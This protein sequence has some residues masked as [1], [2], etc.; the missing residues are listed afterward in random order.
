[1]NTTTRRKVIAG[2]AA[3]P[4]LPAAALAVP[5]TLPL[6]PVSA[7]AQPATAAERLAKFKRLVAELDSREL[8]ALERFM[9]ALG[10]SERMTG[11]D[12]S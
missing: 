2:A 10:A 7:Y 12:V 3:L 6:L 4:L 9:R 11:E 1:M 8:A 5:V